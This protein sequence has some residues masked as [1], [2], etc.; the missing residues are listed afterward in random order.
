MLPGY[1]QVKV[2]H[3]KLPH[4]STIGHE[5]SY[6]FRLPTMMMIN[7]MKKLNVD[8]M[9]SSSE[10]FVSG[11]S[12][13]VILGAVRPITEDPEVSHIVVF[14]YGTIV[15]VSKFQIENY[16]KD[17]P[18]DFLNSQRLPEGIFENVG[19][20]ENI[21]A[22]NVNWW[23]RYKKTLKDD[24]TKNIVANCALYLLT[25]EYPTPGLRSS[26]VVINGFWKNDRDPTKLLSVAQYWNRDDALL[27]LNEDIKS[28][29]EEFAS[30]SRDLN[31]YDYLS[32]RI[33]RILKVN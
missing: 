11:F 14:N 3:E 4:S 2:N 28:S 10:N 25:Y 26:D 20:L 6:T 17:H 12:D 21:W 22:R 33:E 18:Y 8:G 27:M 5:P 9:P 31:R 30:A 19:E 32:P 24:V 23:Y 15:V 7:R 16:Q 1:T 13:E 29:E